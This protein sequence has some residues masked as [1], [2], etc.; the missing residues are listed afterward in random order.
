MTSD[1]ELQEAFLRSPLHRTCGLQTR[2]RPDGVELAGDVSTELA[3]F[4]GSEQ[5]HGGAVAALLD[6]A[7]TLS[8][9]AVTG[10][11]WTTVDLRVDYLTPSPLRGVRVRGSVVRAGRRIA[12]ARAELVGADDVVAAI[13]IG[14]FASASP[15]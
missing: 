5:M 13:G 6:S 8:L 9:L 12:R 4:E 10:E 2:L 3:R 15:K 7:A 14:T 1:A 11:G